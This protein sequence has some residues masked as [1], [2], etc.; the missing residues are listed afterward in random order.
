MKTIVERVREIGP[1]KWRG[2][3]STAWIWEDEARPGFFHLTVRSMESLDDVWFPRP[4]LASFVEEAL[5]YMGA[6]DV[7]S[8]ELE[9]S[10]PYTPGAPK[11]KI[12][13]SVYFVQAVTGGPIK[14]GSAVVVEARVA[15]LQV[16]SPYPL[17]VLGEAVGAGAPTERALHA[18]LAKHRLH[19]EWFEDC[20][21]VRVAMEETLR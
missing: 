8:A 2:P 14:I 3:K 9:P 19:G 16:G 20:P 15:A 4:V 21:E 6:G 5:K 18:R 12:P 1:C 7:V 17:V 10:E 13:A 11:L